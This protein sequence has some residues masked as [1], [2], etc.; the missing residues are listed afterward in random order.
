VLDDPLFYAYNTVVLVND[1]KVWM[2]IYAQASSIICEL[3]PIVQ[4]ALNEQSY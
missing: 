3:L 2:V 4:D 1:M